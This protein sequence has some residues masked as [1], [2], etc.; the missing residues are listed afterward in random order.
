MATASELI[1]NKAKWDSLPARPQGHRRERL[2]GLQRHQRSL[3]PKEQR[4]GDGRPHQEP[5]RHRAAAARR[6]REALRTANT[7]ILDEAVAKDPVT[8]KVH[9]SYMA[10]MAKYKQ[11]ADLQ[12]SSSITTKSS[13]LTRVSAKRLADGI[14]SLIDLVG[15]TTAW[16]ALGIALVMGTQRFAALRFLDRR[17]LDA[18]AR[19][20]PAWRRSACSACRM[21]CVTASMCVS[22]CC[23]QY[24]AAQQAPR[25]RRSRPLLG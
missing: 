16:L 11:W 25:R 20:A 21:R 19:V 24:F 3:V 12:R 18:G 13:R 9:D 2:R 23:S 7:K 6:D 14:D 1:I 8:K 5:G 15:R 10:Y 17:D 22:T 4:R